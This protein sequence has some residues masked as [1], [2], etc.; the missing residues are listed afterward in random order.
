ML[1]AKRKEQIAH[2]ELAGD[3]W[4]THLPCRLDCY[5][6]SFFRADSPQPKRFG[7]QRMEAIHFDE[8]FGQTVRLSVLV[9]RVTDDT[10]ELTI[11]NFDFGE[12]AALFAVV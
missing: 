7:Q 12:R 2:A 4:R 5:F 1:Y 10:T 3:S 8:L 11:G 9:N 6:R